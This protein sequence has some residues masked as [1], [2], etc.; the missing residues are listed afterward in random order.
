MQAY[1]IGII[2]RWTAARV[3]RLVRAVRIDP[4]RLTQAEVGRL[5]RRQP[6]FG[7]SSGAGRPAVGLARQGRARGDGARDHAS[8]RRSVARRRRRPPDR[9]GARGGRRARR[10]RVAPAGLG[11]RASSTRSTTSVSAAR[12]TWSGG[13]RRSGSLVIVEVKSRLTD[14]QDLLARL[15]GRSGS[16]RICLA[17]ERGWESV[18]VGR[19]IVLPGTTANRGV[20][21]RHRAIFDASFPARARC[22][23]RWLRAP[24][25]P[26]LA[27][28]WFVSP[29]RVAAPTR[30]RRVRARRPG[31]TGA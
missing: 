16:S 28:V 9:P 14:L 21:E 26:G 20:V 25:G 3:G 27:A 29:S 10:V 11:R 2:R 22:L 12:S 18:R 15:D 24:E 23:R 7:G 19:V 5:G 1:G 8:A 30:P 17:E 13:M 4:S 31:P 6:A